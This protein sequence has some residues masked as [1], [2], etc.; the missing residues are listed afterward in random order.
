MIMSE[1]D[2]V[3]RVCA[4][5]GPEDLKLHSMEII[6]PKL[7][8]QV[9]V[10]IAVMLVVAFLVLL[11]LVFLVE[12]S[13]NVATDIRMKMRGDC[14]VRDRIFKKSHSSK[15]SFDN[16]SEFDMILVAISLRM[17]KN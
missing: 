9:I 7:N 6:K 17:S 12:E 16:T 8:W 13:L 15:R 10:S 1:P 5:R 2:A 3:N 11:P 4:A 14:R